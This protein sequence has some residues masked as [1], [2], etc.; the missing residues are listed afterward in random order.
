M[1][2][3]I[4]SILLV[5]ILVLGLTGCGNNKELSNKDNKNN[6]NSKTIE[7]EK[8]KVITC[9]LTNKNADESIRGRKSIFEED[10]LIKII[11]FS[12]DKNN[13][14]AEEYCDLFK[15]IESKYENVHIKV[16][17]NNCTITYEINEMTDSDL[18]EL[19]FRDRHDK[20]LFNKMSYNDYYNYVS[21]NPSESCIESNDDN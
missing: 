5:G 13:K 16:E 21:S 3:K 12:N 15:K 1:K 18:E 7:K 10:K 9:T 8:N 11:D 4:L 17:N 2:K 20:T 14:L 19:A 6:S